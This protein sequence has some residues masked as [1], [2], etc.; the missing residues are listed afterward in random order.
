M[1]KEKACLHWQLKI[2]CPDCELTFDLADYDE[3]NDL[4][5]AIFN[6]NWSILKDYEVICPECAVEFMIEDIE[7]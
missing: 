6:N 1:K 7:Y 5:L 4:A 3:E 2:D